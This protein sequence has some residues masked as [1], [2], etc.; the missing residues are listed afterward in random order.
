M[1][2]V[3]NHQ[4]EEMQAANHGHEYGCF[5]QIADMIAGDFIKRGVAY[6]TGSFDEV[7]EGRSVLD[8][9]IERVADGECHCE[10]ED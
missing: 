9:I 1:A 5:E 6:E 10:E 3:I 8:R 4:L 2:S 7:V